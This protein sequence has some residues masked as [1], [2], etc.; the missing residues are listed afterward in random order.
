LELITQGD[1]CPR[2]SHLLIPSPVLRRH[3]E[4]LAALR[5]RHEEAVAATLVELTAGYRRSEEVLTQQVEAKTAD[6]A[7]VQGELDA[8]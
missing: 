8:Q 5:A 7:W 4:E 1:P 3:M 2:H 6:L